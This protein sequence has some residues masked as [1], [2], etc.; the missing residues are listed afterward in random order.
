M[1]IPSDI[2]E[3]SESFK[4]EFVKG[5]EEMMQ[6]QSLGVYI[7]VLANA[8]YDQ[9][10]FDQLSRKLRQ[11]FQRIELEIRSTLTQGKKI[12]ATADD[13]LV[14]LKLMAVGFDRLPLTRFKRCAEFELQFNAL[15]AFRPARMSDIAVTENRAD[16]NAK[17][18]N[19]NKPFLAKETLWQGD[20]EGSHCRLLYNKFPFAQYHALMVLDP[21]DNK[22]QLLTQQDHQKIWQITA[23]LGERL[24]GVGFGYN[25]YGAYASVNHQHFQMFVQDKGV[26]PVELSK[27][28]HN[29]GPEDYPLDCYCHR[30][31]GL[32]W[33]HLQHLNESNQAYNLLYR[34]EA[35][36][37]LPRA[38]QGSYQH[39]GWTSGFAWAELIGAVTTFNQDDFERL[40]AEDISNELRKLAV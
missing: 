18:F 23:S 10:I 1:P 3:S 39:S 17:G 19:F 8:L 26:Y 37:L 33:E 40:C 20:L 2:F 9:A 25:S 5:L 13:E 30:D 27:W 16:F 21:G 7:L 32:A 36:F 6:H 22:S 35:L 15:R 4:Q 12:E 28:Q 38:F 31:S 14:M 24:S 29:G 11:D 34:P